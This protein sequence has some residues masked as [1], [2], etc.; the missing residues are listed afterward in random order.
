M[1]SQREKELKRLIY[2]RNELIKETKKEL[3]ELR[4]ELESLN[5]QKTY[6]RKRG[7]RNGRT[8]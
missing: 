3:K 4:N 8:N 5:N 6:S 2:M 7:G 1:S